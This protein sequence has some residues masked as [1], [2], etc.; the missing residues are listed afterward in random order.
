MENKYSKTEF[1]GF[2]H[3][4]KVEFKTSEPFS[5]FMDIYSNSESYEEL[6]NFINIKK[7]DKVLAFE[8]INRSSKE[9]DDLI[10][11]LLF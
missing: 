3:R 6:N 7:S 8:I 4:F 5:T 9:E 11:E 10:T 1:A 2:T